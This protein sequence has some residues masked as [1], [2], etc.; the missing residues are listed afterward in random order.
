[1]PVRIAYVRVFLYLC[2]IFY[3]N[4][5]MK[6]F[7]YT[8]FKVRIQLLISLL[9]SSV[10]L[11]AAGFTPTEGGLVVD[12]E[13]GDRFLLSVW[14]DLNGNG[15]EEQGEEFFVCDYTDYTGGRFNYTSGHTLKLIPQNHL[16]TEPSETSIWTVKDTLTRTATKCLGGVPGT[17][18]TMWSKAGYTLYLDGKFKTQGKLNTKTDDY[19]A[20]VVFVVPTKQ[21]TASFDP[22]NTLGK[23]GKFSAKKGIG[24]LGM[25]YREVYWLDIPKG[26]SPSSYTNASVVGFNT[27]LASFDYAIEGSKK[28]TAK[29]G[30]ALY[31]FADNKHKPTPRTLFRLYVLD[32]TTVSSCP[33]SNYYF[34][35]SQRFWARYRKV[36]KDLDKLGPGDSTTL[37][38][39]LTMDR[40][41][42]MDSIPGTTYYQTDWMTVPEL[43]S[44]RYYVGYKNHFA[45]TTGENI[46]PFNAQ[47]TFFEELPLQHMP[48]LKAPKGA[49]GRMMADTTKTGEYNL[50]VFFRPAGVFLKVSTGRNVQMHPEP[51]DTSWISNE[52]WHVTEQ[53]AGY[54]YKATL[55][56]GPEFSATD[57][58]FD[59]GGWSV[60]QKGDTVPVVGGGSIVGRDGWCRVYVNKNKHNGGLEFVPADASKWVKYNNNGNFGD[61]IETGYPMLGQTKVAVQSPRLLSDYVFA[62]WNTEPKG[63]GTMY[64]PGVPGK[65]SVDLSGGNVTLYA[66]AEYKG[67]IRV[68]ISFMQGGKRYFLT[69][70][71]VAPRFAT[72]RSFDDWTNTWQGMATVDNVEPEYMSTYL[73]IGKNSI[74]KQCEEDEYILAPQRETMYGAEDSVTFYKNF[75]P[76]NNEYIGLYYTDPNTVLA[77]NTWAGLFVSSKSWPEPMRPCIE[78]TKLFSDAYV[79]TD[80]VS[81]PGR[82]DTVRVVRPNSD[83]SYIKYVSAE[84]TFNGVATSGEATDFTLS[85]V[86]VVDEHYVILPDTLREDQRW[87]DRVVFDL[88]SGKHIQQQ[89]WSKLIGKQLMMQ[90]Q[91]GDEIVYFHPNNDKTFTTANQLWLSRDYR[92]TQSFEFIR[93]S[94]VESL[95]T[96]SDED[97]PHMTESTNDFCRMLNSGLNSP[98]N[99]I[100][101]GEFIDIVDTVRVT[102]RTG[103][104]RIKEDYG[105]WK[106]GAPGLHV[107]PDGSRYRDILVITKTYH[108]GPEV[109]KFVLAPTQPSYTFPPMDNVS[110]RIDFTLSKVRVRELHDKDDNV[111][112]EEILS[113]EDETESLHMGP[114]DCSITGGSTYFRIGEV[115]NAHANVITQIENTTG[116]DHDTLVVSTTAHVDGEDHVVSCRVPLIQTAMEMEEVIWSVEGNGNRYYIMAGS[117]GLIFRQFERKGNTLYKKT[118]GVTQLIEGS[119]DAA[120]SD[121]RYITPW[122]FHIPD[123]SKKQVEFYTLYGVNKKFY[124]DG[125]SR[126]GLA[127]GGNYDGAAL[128][129]YEYVTENFN[130]NGNFEEVIKIKYG[131]YW[132]KFTATA[133]TVYLS[134]TDQAEEAAIFS[135]TYLKPEYYLM[136]NGDYP[137]RERLEFGYNKLTISSVTTRY[138][139]YRIY[140]MLVGNQF[141]YCGRLDEADIADL[142]NASDIWKTNYTINHIQ[143][144][145][146][147]TDSSHLSISTDPV[148]LVTTV[149]PSGDSP[150]GTRYPAGSGPH[151]NIVDTLDV[152]ISLQTGAHA[153]GFKDQWSEY[154]SVDDAHLKIP[155]VRKTYH[156][157]AYDSLICTVD[158]DE[159]TYVFPPEVTPTVNDEHTFIFRTAHHKG[160]HI[161]DTEGTAVAYTNA[162]EDSHTTDMHLNNA[163]LAE[164]RLMDEYGNS[165]DWCEISS[166]GSN[167]I[168]VHCKGNG[169]RS[170]RSA[171]IYLAYTLQVEGVWRYVNFRVQV[172]QAS[173]FQYRGNQHLIHSKG[174]SGADLKDEVQQVHEN[175][176]II[177]YYNP[178]NAAQS[179]DQRVELPLRERNFYGWWRWYSLEDGL[180]DTDIPAEKWQT[181][182][183]NTGKYNFP[184]RTIGDSVWVD[185]ADHSKGKKL[186]TQGRYTVFHV[187]SQEYGARKDPPS[188]APMVYPPQNKDTVVYAVDISVYYDNLPLS[189]RVENQ[190]DT[191]IMD[192][193]QQIIEPTLSLREIYELHPWT[194]MA[195]RMENYKDTIAS[196]TRNLRY[197]EDHTIMA[198]TDVT[199]L[200]TTEQ[201]Y[202]YENV[203]KSKHS[204]SLMGYYM[205]DDNWSTWS[206]VRQDSMIW[207]GG[208][209]VP[210]RW[211][212]FNPKN[213]TYKICNY[214]VL[215]ANDFLQVA[216]KSAM[217]TGQNTDTVIYCLRARSWKTL[218]DKA[219]NDSTVE[220][221]Y[222]F[223]ICRYTIIY[224]RPEKYGPKLEDAHGKAIITND[225]IE[226]SFEVLERLN[227]DYNK[228]GEEY[229][230]YPHPLPWGDASYGFAYP[231]TDALPDNRVHNAQGLTNLANMGEYNLINRI[232]EFGK[233][234]HKMEQHGGAE[235]G[236]MIFCDGMSSAGQVAALRLDTTLCEGQKMYF[237][238]FVANPGNESGKS[239]PNFLFSV[240]GSRDGAD[241][242]DITSYMT[243]YIPQSTKWHQIYFPI[244]QSEEYTNFRVRVY[245]MAANDDGNDFIIDDMCLFATKPPL[246]VYQANT[247]CKTGNEN[248]SI[249]HIVLR[250]D[251]QGFPEELDAL[252]YQYYTIQQITRAGVTSFVKLEDGYYNEVK[253][254]AILPATADTIYG[255]IDLPKRHYKPL[256]TDSIYPNLS[257]LIDAFE[258][259]LEAHSKDASV[260]VMREGYVFEHLDDSIRPVLYIVHSAKM[261]A[262]NTYVARMAGAYS[263]LL[264]SKCGL[265]R[266][267]KV[268]NRM[269][270]TLNGE[271]QPDKEVENMCAG[272]LYDVSLRVKGTLL[273]DSV[274]P[275]E[276]TGTCYN[277]WLLY[278]DTAAVSSKARY[279]YYY[280]DIAKVMTILRSDDAR[281]NNTNQFAHSLVDVNKNIMQKVQGDLTIEL[282]EHVEPYVILK[283]LVDSGFLTLYKSDLTVVT[284]HDSAIQ[285]TIFPIPGTGTEVLA[286]M[287]IDVCPTPVQIRLESHAG[288]GLPLVIGGLKRPE[289]EL[290]YPIV[291]L[292]DSVHA[293]TSLRIPIDSL[294]MDPS[295]GGTTPKVAMHQ[296]IFLSTNDPHY[297]PGVDTI[298]LEPDRTWSLTGGENTGYYQNGHDTLVVV[299]VMPIS[300]RMRD[301]YSYTFGIEMM[302]SSTGSTG[303][304]GD[305]HDCPVGTIPFTISVVPKYLRW[306]PQT[307]DNKWNNPDN[308]IG[309]KHDNTPIHEEARFAPLQSCYV[310]IPPMTDGKPYPVLPASIPFE[311]SIQQVGFQYNVCHS[312]RFLPGAAMSQQQR[313]EYD[314]VIADLSTPYNKWALRSSPVEGLLSGDIF[315]SNADLTWETPTWAVGPFDAAGRTHST[316]N[317]SFWLSLY[318]T[319]VTHQDNTPAV[320]TWTTTAA[321]WSKVTNA[322]TLP[323]KPA[324]GWAVFTRTHSGENAAVRLPKNDDIYYYYTKSGNKVL[325][326]YESGLRAKRAES[327]GGADKAGKMA[328]YPG[329]AATSKSYTLSNGTAA[330]NFVFGNPTLGYIDIWGFIADNTLLLDAEIGYMNALGE[331]TTITQAALTEPEAITSLSRYLPPMQAIMLKKKGDADT[332]LTVTLNTNRI[333]TAANQITR[334]LPAPAYAPRR[335][336]MTNDQLPIEKGIMTITAVNPASARCVSRLLLGQGFNDEILRGE[337]ALLTTL[338]IDNYTATSMPSTPFNIYAIE[339]TNGLCIDLRSEIVNVPLSFYNNSDLPFD[340]ISYLWF[341]GVNAID[342]EL[343]LYDALTDTERPIMDG[344]YHE[345]ETPE[346]SHEIRYFIRRPGFNPNDPGEDQPITTG[347]DQ[348]VNDT[349]E[350]YKFIKDGHVLIL[351]DGHVYTVFGQK[352]R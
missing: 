350:I 322:I 63:S 337:D 19:A 172:M 108:H 248:D 202:N 86:G 342:G 52:M 51:G 8:S 203:K 213:K 25:P 201:R 96:V 332:E 157:A 217:P 273:L 197:L 260:K 278:G 27:T 307:S 119:A 117:G 346:V 252:G 347:V 338:N 145:R 180:E 71:G 285:Y 143:D 222:W 231:A 243:G 60:E 293:N 10:G 187:P 50:G 125:S 311:D 309:V 122:H 46:A 279:G 61:T 3:E 283:H 205:R 136:N 318:S 135:W 121:T 141:T 91:L 130:D 169:V 126:P 173:K 15:T 55:Y 28:E 59:I 228:P 335:S 326:L 261:D 237:S 244:E 310:V 313:L 250:V 133:D 111:L 287:N 340:T 150:L 233:Y 349:S 298:V 257:D 303:W 94:R 254:P 106:D 255:K 16:A 161:L 212:T 336:A 177:Y 124:F 144:S 249:T 186:V 242:H 72:A 275:I 188:K 104:N 164:V 90:M 67:K 58:G 120:N 305:E 320:E 148:T 36:E 314:S 246:M 4:L 11:Y 220:G 131:T 348:T 5:N 149:T 156:E 236:Y 100:Y 132:L 281:T 282:S 325:D 113:S 40:L 226:Q 196:G 308:W 116:E 128:L 92:L 84:G 276:V 155:L 295:T 289:E 247:T 270:L 151:V 328:F 158:R 142:I 76:E 98:I 339:G 147:A 139:A 163:A 112:G 29:P 12:L 229:T 256:S 329:K 230:V 264:S 258:T 194:E 74:C 291:V 317:A 82:K 238:G 330:S 31:S 38:S 87:V 296:I 343:V 300:Y 174:A 262:K 13:N 280:S 190:V 65:D 34:A 107:L 114:G 166:I 272:S 294:M 223:N 218:E 277:D 185:E 83:K 93:D 304:I 154:T 146:F 42:C 48:G 20:D 232:P 286:D 152:Q 137:S 162:H 227:F 134:L 129:T 99:V 14:I 183:M 265:T 89:V 178:S 45:R 263:Q 200:L 101:K 32:E 216:K 327:A 204:E 192:T 341:T 195:E 235:N 292:A 123:H 41:H 179:T 68:A 351:R 64:I 85:G 79:H 103:T 81:N 274:A 24:F 127:D 271:E 49:F 211:Y 208:W 2:T 324:Q 1:M 288:Q 334:P 77:N 207:C 251:Y 193:L 175:R 219:G 75:K 47:Y 306:D 159:Y 290:Q 118:D 269:I 7:C 266:A 153:Y 253:K 160:T 344:I 97:R 57:P 66:I 259:S 214:T 168:T 221:A 53:Y 284:P 297:R 22:N 215:E 165:P 170:P 331:Y 210:C 352:I 321:T 171:S 138:K 56:S 54:T 333:V 206:G 30:Q 37:A 225:E 301:S 102:L 95:G 44:C 69:H 109:D 240:Q 267:L 167:T 33:E 78:N 35:Y 319:D 17:Y 316:G 189:M 345:I 234:W 224:H 39:F 9:F 245:N 199:L 21:A 182:P 43:D 241:W 302:M 209:D 323:L 26:N 105:I 198:P 110:H 23:G 239:C 312:I 299:P 268:R 140:S 18:Y 315:M 6:K 73:L 191:A 176:T 70:P 115:V 181:P 184:Y 88:H 80:S 62:G